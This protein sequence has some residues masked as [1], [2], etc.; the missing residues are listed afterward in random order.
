MLEKV[1]T[2]PRRLVRALAIFMPIGFMLLVGGCHA[3]AG[4]GQDISA[5]GQAITNGAKKS[6]PDQ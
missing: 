6:T 2:R 1:V 4:A 3:T 5:T